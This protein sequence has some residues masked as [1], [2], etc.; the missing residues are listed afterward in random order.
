MYIVY[1]A[2]KLHQIIWINNCYRNIKSLH[3]FVITGITLI[4][5][6]VHTANSTSHRD[7]GHSLPGDQQCQ[8]GTEIH[9]YCLSVSISKEWSPW[10]TGFLLTDACQRRQKAQFCCVQYIAF[11]FVTKEFTT[12]CTSLD[13]PNDRRIIT[14]MQYTYTHSCLVLTCSTALIHTYVESSCPHL[15]S[16]TLMLKPHKLTCTHTHLY[17]ILYAVP[18]ALSLSLSLSHAHTVYIV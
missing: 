8:F 4:C 18:H 2:Q 6:A 16:H 1:M 14:D 7:W 13:A 17:C 5:T 12:Y 10:Y 3:L 9:C 11:W 15:Y